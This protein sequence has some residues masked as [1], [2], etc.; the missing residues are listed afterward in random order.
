MANSRSWASPFPRPPSPSIGFA[1]ACH[2]PILGGAFS[3]I[4]QTTWCRS[5]FSLCRPQLSEF[6][7][8]SSSFATTVAVSFISMSPN[9]L[10]PSGRRSKWSMAFPWDTAPRYLVRDR[11]QTYGAYFDTRVDGL[12]MEQV[13]TAPRSPWQNPF[14]ERMISSI[15]RECLDHVIV[16]DERHLKRILR[17]YVDYYHSCRTHLSLEKDAPEP[18]RVESPA[19]GK[20]RAIPKVGG[21]HH[22]YTLRAA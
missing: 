9:I 10:L 15:R 16:L 5:T 2:R 7:S 21:L 19:M 20:V 1:I 12:G 8:S 3:I 14:V 6:C 17:K 4:M 18:R 13:L 11:D 22:H